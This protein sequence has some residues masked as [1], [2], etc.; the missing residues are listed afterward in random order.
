MIDRKFS[1]RF[2]IQILNYYDRRGNIIDY[3]R[4]V[5]NY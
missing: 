2:I 5:K 1:D 3:K 4:L